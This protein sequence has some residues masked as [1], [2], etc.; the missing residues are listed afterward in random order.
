MDVTCSATSD[1]C[2]SAIECTFF[3]CFDEGAVTECTADVEATDCNGNNCSLTM[4]A[5]VTGDSS[6]VSFLWGKD[7]GYYEEY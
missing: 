2:S 6:S 4:N 5:Q 1:E 7:C 3:N